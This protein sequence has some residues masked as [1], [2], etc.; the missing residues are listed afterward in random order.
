MTGRLN[1][2]TG[3]WV[4]LPVRLALGAIFLVHGIQKVAPIWGG[5]GLAAWTSGTAPLNLQPSWAWLTAAAFA[6]LIG[7]LL[8]FLGLFTRVGALLIAAVMAVAMFGV[9][10]PH[11]FF[12]TSGGFEYT[13]A[14]LAMA[15]TLLMAGGGNGSIDYQRYGGG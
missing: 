14:L 8:V 6:E 10:W 13:M 11:G 3:T 7:G 12:L 2:T 5:R 9:H 15:L 4:L 1:A